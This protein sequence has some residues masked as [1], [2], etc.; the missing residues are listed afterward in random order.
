MN[1]EPEATDI[2]ERKYMVIATKHTLTSIKHYKIDSKRDRILSITDSM[3]SVGKTQHHY[4]KYSA[5][6]QLIQYTAEG[7]Y[8]LLVSYNGIKISKIE[9]K[10]LGNGELHISY[11]YT[12]GGDLKLL[13]AKITNHTNNRNYKVDYDFDG[14]RLTKESYYDQSNKKLYELEIDPDYGTAYST[15]FNNSTEEYQLIEYEVREFMPFVEPVIGIVEAENYDFGVY[16]N[17]RFEDDYWSERIEAV[18]DPE[19]A[20]LVNYFV[21]R[22]YMSASNKLLWG[23]SKYE[24][25]IPEKLN[26]EFVSQ[27]KREVAYYT[28]IGDSF[29]LEVMGRIDGGTLATSGMPDGLSALVYDSTWQNHYQMENILADTTKNNQAY[30]AK[31]LM[32]EEPFFVLKIGDQYMV[33]DRAESLFNIS[34]MKIRDNLYSYIP[35]VESNFRLEEG[36]W[37]V[38]GLS[39]Y[40]EQETRISPQFFVRIDDTHFD[41]YDRGKAIKGT[42]ST[43]IDDEHLFYDPITN[44]SYQMKFTKEFTDGAHLGLDE[45]ENRFSEATLLSEESIFIAVKIE[46]TGAFKFFYKGQPIKTADFTVSDDPSNSK[47]KVFAVKSTSEKFLFPNWEA[48]RANQITV[49]KKF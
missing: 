34:V 15:T 22:A 46:S 47:N 27:G 41:F 14:D 16:Y 42:I 8:E 37:T 4:F 24:P 17:Y 32:S 28:L 20:K 12:Y 5:S 6:D 45:I 9:K 33:D 3:L 44:Y 30:R 43:L 13:S 38:P 31:F 35:E 36:D 23:V 39:Y 10:P 11:E 26:P 18:H 2:F 25:I 21:C 49:L 19:N 7:E 1:P 40:L 48:T 29:Q